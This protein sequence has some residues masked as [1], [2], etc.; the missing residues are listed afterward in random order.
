MQLSLVRHRP[1]AAHDLA[2][3][4]YDSELLAFT[5][6]S[7]IEHQHNFAGVIAWAPQKIILMARNCLGQIELSA[8]E[9]NRAG[10]P[11]VLAE[12]C[13]AF[14]VFRT[15]VMIDVR[16]RGDHFFP[17]ELIGENLRQ[18][19]GVQRLR[20]R[21]L[22]MNR[23]HVW[24]QFLRRQNWQRQWRKQSAQHNNWTEQRGL[25]PLQTRSKHALDS[26]ASRGK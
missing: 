17:A 13:S 20:A 21:R 19:S 9:I 16:D 3:I 10:L 24:D 6:S 1:W 26:Y 23:L 12:N 11:V 22:E 2:Q 5:V 18:R 15:Q 4:F 7:L 25:E 14:P 8:E